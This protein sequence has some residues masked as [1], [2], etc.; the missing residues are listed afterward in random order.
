MNRALACSAIFVWGMFPVAVGAA[1][2]TY[3]SRSAWESAVGPVTGTEAFSSFEFDKG[4]IS[5]DAVIVENMTLQTSAPTTSGVPPES[6]NKVD[7]S[8]F[9]GPGYSVNGTTFAFVNIE[10]GENEFRID[11]A[12]PVVAWG[13]DFNSLANDDRV[14]RISIHDEANLLL[15]A[16]EPASLPGSYTVRFWGF[17][18]TEGAA[19][20]MR[21]TYV[22]P[23][24]VVGPRDT[25]GIDDIAFV[26]DV[27][28]PA[29][30]CLFG[31]LAG[32]LAG[33][34]L[35]RERGRRT[36]RRS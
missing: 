18:L 14:T 24:G 28:E 21:F 16:I 8:P 2:V 20:S 7:V 32:A 34:A 3:D 9:E 27:P 19:A 22:G 5:P 23:S 15:D 11:F 17:A 36:R 29:S 26:T 30:V 6:Q 31:S 4:F 33:A 13:A 10:L 1:V 35:R 12:T 25:F